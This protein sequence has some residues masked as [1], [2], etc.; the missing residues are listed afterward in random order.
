MS[1]PAKRRKNLYKLGYLAGALGILV[2]SFAALCASPTVPEPVGVLFTNGQIY[3]SNPAQP[4]AEAIAIRGNKIAAVGSNADLQALRGP[5]TKTI[6]LAGRMAMPGI[7]DTHTHFLQASELLAGPS[8]AG[9]TSVD[10]VRARLTEFEKSHPGDGWIFGGGWDYGSF[11]PGGLPTKALLDEVFPNRPVVMLAS[12]AHS[13]WVNSA[14]LARARIARET[15]DPNTAELHGIIVRDAKTG[16]PTGVLEEGAQYLAYTAID[17]PTALRDLRDGMVEASRQGITGVVNATGDEHEIALYEQLHQR[18]ELTVRTT[19][20]FSGGVGTRFTLSD[21]EL[22]RFEELRKKFTGDWVRSGPVKFFADGVVETHTAAMLEPYANPKFPGEKGSLLYTP[23]ELQRDFFILDRRGFQVMTH[24]V[25]DGAVR[26][27]LDAYE[28]VEKQDGLRDRRWRLEHMEVV[29]AADRRRP[30]EMQI[31]AA[32]QP[33]CCAS[34]DEPWG[35]G[36]GT[37]RMADG[38]PWQD[39]VSAGATLIMG[40]DW[41]VEPINPF[42]IMQTGLTRQTP[43]GQPAGGFFPKQALTLDQML[44]GYT[45]NAAYSE[46]MEDRLG[47]LN[48]G[49]LA[50]VIVLSQNLFKVAPNTVGKTEVLLT[51]V[52][53]KIV[54]REGL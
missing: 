46:F 27:V 14:A 26:A 52:D 1:T 32:F 50:D 44:A 6:D 29:S 39:V 23:Q 24:A 16:E 11:W 54:R 22:A 8:V 37:A 7:I 35:A 41:P 10:A 21:A 51:V 42:V 3:T 38:I 40:S 34:L 17:D 30:A 43:D 28:A 18:G 31:L 48:P 12:D 13:V 9:L 15:P 53:G 2:I 5:N 4:W 36:V 25:G 20:A 47:Q 45:R 19:T 49:Y 33:W